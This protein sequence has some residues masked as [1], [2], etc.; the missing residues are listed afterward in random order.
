MPISCLTLPNHLPHIANLWLFISE[1][2]TG[3]GL[4]AIYDDEIG[5]MP[6]I[7]ADPQVVIKML[8]QAHQ[9]ARESGKRIKLIKMTRREELQVIE[10]NPM[11]QWD[12]M[13]ETL[14]E[15]P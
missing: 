1:D 9:I 12:S 4:C 7:T 3:E 10:A 2:S 8:P 15:T 14:R 13:A 6:M 5:W 11:D